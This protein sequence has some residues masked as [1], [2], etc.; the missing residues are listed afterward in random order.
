MRI[1][2][3]PLTTE[4]NTVPLTNCDK[5]LCVQMQRGTLTLW[6]QINEDPALNVTK[7]ARTFVI[8]PT[9]DTTKKGSFE[10]VG[11]VQDGIFVWHVYERVD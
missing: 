6:A 4:E 8:F 1:H 5:V 9:G 10:Y 3:Y 7:R 2:K 11:T